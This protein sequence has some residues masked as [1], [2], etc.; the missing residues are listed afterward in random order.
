MIFLKLMITFFKIGLF[1]YGGGLSM[2]PLLQDEIVTKHGWLTAQQFIDMIAI[3]ESTPGPIGINMAT[4]VGFKTA[5]VLGSV[6]ASVSVCMPS[7][8]IVIILA[9]YFM[10]FHE[11]TIVKSAFSG[12]RPAVTGLIAAAGFEVAKVALV[13]IQKF[14]DTGKLVDLLDLK[15]ILLFAAML[16]AILKWNRHP[17]V[18]IAVAAVI[19]V[20]FKF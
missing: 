8:I 12:L 9:H 4:F 19:G 15:M 13:D 5:G 17:I 6:L 14:V 2:L 10:K 1:S 7:L 11:N 20:I 16:F 3:S 18:Y